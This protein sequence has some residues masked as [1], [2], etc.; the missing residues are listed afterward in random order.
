MQIS[1]ETKVGAL[2]VI[3]VTLLVLGYNFLTGKSISGKSNT[4]Y[5]KFT[6]VGALDIANPVKIKGFRIGNVSDISS[7]DASVSEVIVSI[8]LQE[9]VKI[10]SNSV[11]TIINSLTGTSSIN[12]IPGNSKEFISYGDTLLST[13]SP[14]LLSK[15]MNNVDPLLISVK[16]AVDTLQ[17]LLN[18]F[19]RVLDLPTQTHFRSII[20]ELDQSSK[21]LSTLLN[22]ENGSL[23]NTLKNADTFTQNLNT[24]NNNI[25]DIINN[26]KITAQQLSESSI[27]ETVTQLQ[28]TLSEV[29]V[30][31][32]KA[33]SKDGSVGML[34]NDPTL[35]NNLQQTSRSLTILIDDLKT[36]P[37]RYVSLSIFGKKDKTKPLTA[38]LS[39]TVQQQQR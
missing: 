18:G 20:K 1:N 3:A 2:T 31:L 39:D 13:V 28:N 34:L 22:P 16:S 37:K 33:S 12:I 4:I 10:P 11:A 29:Q 26:L 38:P 7:S 15:V 36:N 9:T 8:S 25:N 21:S 6:D 23:A 14:D 27:K 32:K 24:N 30:L 17:Q 19:N 5:V 35:Y